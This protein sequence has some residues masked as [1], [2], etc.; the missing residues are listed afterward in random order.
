MTLH[1]FQ[2]ELLRLGAS[3][4]LRGS[5]AAEFVFAERQGRAVELSRSQEQ[6][7]VEF[8]ERSNDENA[9]ATKEAF[10]KSSTEV[11]EAIAAWLSL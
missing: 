5:G 1:D 10:Y 2:N 11:L 9:P 4:S 3:A 8:W 7:F 6:W